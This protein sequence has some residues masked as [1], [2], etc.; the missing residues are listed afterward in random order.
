MK[1]Y[2]QEALSVYKLL[3]TSKTYH[4]ITKP[5]VKQQR[6]LWKTIYEEKSKLENGGTEQ[7][8]KAEALMLLK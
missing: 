1:A 6:K 4:I 7:D 5:I 2:N 3:K 8:G